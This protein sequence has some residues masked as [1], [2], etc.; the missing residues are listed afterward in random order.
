MLLAHISLFEFRPDAIREDFEPMFPY[1]PDGHHWGQPGEAGRVNDALPTAGWVYVKDEMMPPSLKSEETFVQ[2]GWAVDEDGINV[3][4]DVGEDEEGEAE[5]ARLR[6]LGRSGSPQAIA[7][8]L[9]R[10]PAGMN[11]PAPMRPP[12]ARGAPSVKEG[13][14]GGGRS[15]AAGRSEAPVAATPKKMF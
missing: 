10:A 13:S 12:P 2:G 7:K 1:V 15:P 5:R 9:S 11:L 4:E 3:L 14:L 6:D 8:L